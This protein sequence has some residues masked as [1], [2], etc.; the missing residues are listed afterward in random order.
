MIG[1]LAVD[2]SRQS[3]PVYLLPR[4]PEADAGGRDWSV[5]V[6]APTQTWSIHVANAFEERDAGRGGGTTVRIQMS[7]CS[8]RWFHFHRMFGYDWLN[9]KLDPSFMNVAKGRELLP[10]LVQVTKRSGF[11]Y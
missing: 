11:C 8:Y 4:S 5:P 9:K 3:T 7:G 6:E 1:A 10:R 2:P